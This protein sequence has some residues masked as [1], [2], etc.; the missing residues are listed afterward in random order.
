MWLFHITCAWLFN[1]WIFNFVCYVKIE[2]LEIAESYTH[3][4]AFYSTVWC[5]LEFML[6]GNVIIFR[7]LLTNFVYF[8]FTNGW[9]WD[10][11][12]GLKKKKNLINLVLSLWSECDKC[13]YTLGQH[14]D[15]LTFTVDNHWSKL[16]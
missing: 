10:Y 3:K 9:Y 15:N 8:I 14:I 16:A 7:N 13:I 4:V 5:R 11:T 6:L 1:M 2:N 12:K